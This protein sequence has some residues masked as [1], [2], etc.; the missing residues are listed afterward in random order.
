MKVSYT[1]NNIQ[2]FFLGALMVLGFQETVSYFLPM[3]NNKGLFYYLCVYLSM[4]FILGRVTKSH[5]EFYTR[6]EQKGGLESDTTK[7]RTTSIKSNNVKTDTSSTNA[8]RRNVQAP[9]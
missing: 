3:I 7:K 6:L 5:A 1:V 4:G 2:M 8:N 9:T